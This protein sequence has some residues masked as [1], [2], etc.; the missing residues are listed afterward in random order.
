MITT[1]GFLRRVFINGADEL[2][3]ESMV[4]ETKHNTRYR[5][6]KLKGS[7]PQ[8]A[9]ECED[10]VAGFARCTKASIAQT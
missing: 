9:R 8:I 5:Y 7:T 10:P 6:T 2:H 3:R 1:G 4:F